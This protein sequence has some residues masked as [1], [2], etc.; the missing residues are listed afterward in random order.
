[1]NTPKDGTPTSHGMGPV[2]KRPAPAAPP[3]WRPYKPGIEINDH[4][5]LRTRSP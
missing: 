1:M 2:V 5:Q 3:Q 4:G